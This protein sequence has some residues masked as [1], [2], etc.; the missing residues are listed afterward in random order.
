MRTVQFIL[1]PRT[2]VFR[3][4]WEREK[5]FSLLILLLQ[6]LSSQSSSAISEY[7]RLFSTFLLTPGV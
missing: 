3:H 2:M 5:K 4:F 1:N 7:Q 6:M